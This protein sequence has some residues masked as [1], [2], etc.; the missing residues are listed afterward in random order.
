MLKKNRKNNYGLI[1]IQIEY[2]HFEMTIKTI[3]P[4]KKTLRLYV[5]YVQEIIKIQLLKT[6]E[7]IYRKSSQFSE[8]EKNFASTAFPTHT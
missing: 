6:K 5:G 7:R 1:K 2:I 8:T 3:R 4:I